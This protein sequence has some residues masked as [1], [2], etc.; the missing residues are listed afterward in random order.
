MSVPSYHDE[1]PDDRQ[2][3]LQ[4]HARKALDSGKSDVVKDKAVATVLDA[5]RTDFD[6]G[7]PASFA[8]DVARAARHRSEAVRAVQSFKQRL[9]QWLVCTVALLLASSV[10]Y[11]SWPD[12]AVEIRGVF[13]AAPFSGLCVMTVALA[14]LFAAVP[15]N[16]K[17]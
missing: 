7:L 3:R 13:V 10:R 9:N 17:I 8:S 15:R 5:L 11:V 6:R 2:W 12:V 1:G 14:I 4:E 16:R